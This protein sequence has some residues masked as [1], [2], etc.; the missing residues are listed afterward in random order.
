MR[1]HPQ[2]AVYTRLYKNT[3]FCNKPTGTSRSYNRTP[4]IGSI[5]R[6]SSRG[7]TGHLAQCTALLSRIRCRRPT[8]ISIVVSGQGLIGRKIKNQ[9]LVNYMT[10]RNFD[11]V[12]GQLCTIFML[13]VA[14]YTQRSSE[15]I[16][17]S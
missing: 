14:L 3:L 5:L 7:K 6:S 2:R 12:I 11:W 4:A 16:Q 1:A 10:L 17:L 15:V 9:L 8:L 13:I